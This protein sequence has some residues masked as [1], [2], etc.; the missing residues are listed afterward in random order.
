MRIIMSGSQNN[1]FLPSLQIVLQY[2]KNLVAFIT[3][4]HIG[5]FNYIVVSVVGPT[6]LDPDILGLVG[7]L[8]DDVQND[9]IAAD[10]FIL[11]DL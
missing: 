11:A 1:L 5:V 7:I 4:L 9:I 8:L 10:D 2:L 3:W 6:L